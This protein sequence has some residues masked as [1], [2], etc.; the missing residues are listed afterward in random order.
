MIMIRGALLS[1]ALSLAAASAAFAQ[2]A[3]P[4]PPPAESGP[5]FASQHNCQITTLQRC[6]AGGGC[7]PLDNLKGEKLPVKMT[8]DLDAGIVA[9]VDAN[10][11]VDATRI[12]SVARTGDGI[13]LQGIDGVTAW[14]M[15]IREKD[16]GLSL[17]LE[18]ADGTSVGF[19]TCTAVKAP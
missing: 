17:S 1:A 3:S 10:G 8:I 11:W 9:G 12:S 7:A 5:P 2:A 14:Q 16:D 4:P 19:G 18:G 13:I 6:V 15:L